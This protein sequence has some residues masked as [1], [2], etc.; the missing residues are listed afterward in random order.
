MSCGLR[1]KNMTSKVIAMVDIDGC[2]HVRMDGELGL[3]PC[4]GRQH[5]NNCSDLV[6]NCLKGTAYYDIRIT[7]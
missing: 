3:S 2:T 5:D 4:L 7:I 6:V 1:V